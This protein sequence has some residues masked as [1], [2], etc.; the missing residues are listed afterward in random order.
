MALSRRGDG[1]ARR[2]R[3][4]GRRGRARELSLPDDRRRDA[5]RARHRSGGST[6]SRSARRSSRRRSTPPQPP[7]GALQFERVNT[8]SG[9]ADV[10]FDA[11]CGAIVGVTGLAGAGQATV[12]ELVGPAPGRSGPVL[13]PDGRP[14]RGAFAARSRRDRARHGDRRR[15]GLMLD[16]PIWDNIAQ[17]RAIAHSREGWVIRK[18]GCV[19]EPAA[20]SP[21]AD[22]STSAIA[23]GGSLSG[24]NQQKVVF[25][26]WLEPA[27]GDG[28]R[29][30]DTRRR[31]QRQGRDALDVPLRR[32]RHGSCC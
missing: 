21:R 22:R 15:F 18:R 12:L 14:C 32:G 8:R 7:A 1:A 31:R 25:A 13:L 10:S 20:I 26:K 16:K 5:R 4:D 30:P 24:G 6:T 29:R 23:K 11:P 3:R 19:S 2:A 9:L 28:A 27:H 17:V